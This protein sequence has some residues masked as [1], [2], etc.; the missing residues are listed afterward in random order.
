MRV[1]LL[2]TS[3]GIPIPKR[4]QSGI[5]VETRESKILLDCGM[6]VPLRMAEAGVGIEE[7]DTVCITHEHLDHVQDLPSLIKASRL[8]TGKARYE[9]VIP[10]GLKE[11]L[12][13]F[14]SSADGSVFE[15]DEVELDLRVMKPGEEMGEDLSLRSFKTAHT[16]MSQGYELSLDGNKMIYTG[17]T[18]A[19][20]EVRRASE[21]KDLVIHELSSLEKTE[22][23]TDPEELISELSDTPIERL[24]LTH[25]YPDASEKADQIADKVEREIGVRTFSGED[26]LSFEI[27]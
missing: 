25:F 6:G 2:G 23:H 9:I 14:C 5:L 16:D 1:T 10:P 13:R 20:G 19:S 7:V 12:M 24:V 27:S 17:D 21:G 15:D 4:A 8:K 26:L 11:R 18:E 3:A 22:G